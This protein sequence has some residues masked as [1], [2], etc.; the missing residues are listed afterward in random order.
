[1][2]SYSHFPQPLPGGP[3]LTSQTSWGAGYAGLGARLGAYFLDG[4][5]V[6]IP[7][8]ILLGIVSEVHAFASPSSAA[9]AL[10]STPSSAP[11]LLLEYAVELVTEILYFVFCWSTRGATLGQRALKIRVVDAQTG[12]PIDGGRA[13]VRWLGYV[14][15]GLSLGLGFLWCVWDRRKQTWADKMARTIVVRA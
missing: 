12:G 2:S 9:A 3:P 7:L 5:F 14:V 8:W 6:S 10:G 1:M 11:M 13:F 4:I 15:S